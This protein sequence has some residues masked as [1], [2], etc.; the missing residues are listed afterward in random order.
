MI[1]DNVVIN[2]ALLI[3]ICMLIL[4]PKLFYIALNICQCAIVINESAA[5]MGGGGE[6][7]A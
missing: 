7:V 2:F 1:E 6:E 4:A 5:R 3:H